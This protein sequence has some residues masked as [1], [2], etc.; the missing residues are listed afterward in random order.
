[1][2]S[3]KDPEWEQNTTENI[4]TGVQPGQSFS[5]SQKAWFLLGSNNSSAGLSQLLIYLLLLKFL[6][7]RA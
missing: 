3:A 2:S 7:C 1:V 4:T 5:Q 6:N